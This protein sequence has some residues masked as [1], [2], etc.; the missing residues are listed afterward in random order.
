MLL[1][2]S[3]IVSGFIYLGI[4]RYLSPHCSFRIVSFENI[5]RKFLMQLSGISS[6]KR[7]ATT[8]S[9]SLPMQSVLKS[10]IDA[11]TLNVL[12]CVQANALLPIYVRPSFSCISSRPARR[13]RHSLRLTEHFLAKSKILSSRR[14]QKR[15]LQLLPGFFQKRQTQGFCTRKRPMF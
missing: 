6:L 11:G 7:G 4:Y 14:I 2:P 13:E 12:I 8:S 9:I 3:L 1:R 5:G 10:A 15:H